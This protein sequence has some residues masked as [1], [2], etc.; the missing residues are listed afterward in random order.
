VAEKPQEKSAEEIK[1][2]N[3][4]MMA[5][6]AIKTALL[7][8]NSKEAPQIP[9]ELS[10]YWNSLTTHE[11]REHLLLFAR[12]LKKYKQPKVKTILFDIE[13]YVKDCKKL[14][15]SFKRTKEEILLMM[16]IG[17]IK[18]SDF[19]ETLSQLPSNREKLDRK[20]QK[21]IKVLDWEDSQD[22]DKLD[23]LTKQLN[24]PKIKKSEIEKIEKQITGIEQNIEKRKSIRDGLAIKLV[25]WKTRG[26][27]DIAGMDGQFRLDA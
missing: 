27:I 24:N 2:E 1:A 26:T 9:P 25:E 16:A 15:P 6:A 22:L 12:E 11:W 13:N 20:I 23:D 7:S 10:Q 8:F 17:Q 14:V 5:K 3:D 4:L 18:S 21:Q 19:I